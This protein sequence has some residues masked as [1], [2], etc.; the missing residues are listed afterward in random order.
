MTPGLCN[1]LDLPADWNGFAR[2]DSGEEELGAAGVGWIGC[3]HGEGGGRRVRGGS[4]RGAGRSGVA[5][6]GGDEG[7][8]H[9]RSFLCH[10]FILSLVCSQM[11]VLDAHDRIY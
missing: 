7:F 2:G 5:C 4:R 3:L 10:E 1:V 6:G 11:L 8:G 9:L